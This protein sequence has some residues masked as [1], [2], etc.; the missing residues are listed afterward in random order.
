M[1]SVIDVEIDAG[2]GSIAD[3]AVLERRLRDAVN[4][5]PS[6]AELWRALAAYQVGG[7]RAI[8]L[9]WA[10]AAEAR[11]MEDT[12]LPHPTRS[13][14]PARPRVVAGVALFVALSGA[15]GSLELAFANEVVLPGI[16]ANGLDLGG[17]SR[18][19]ALTLLRAAAEQRAARPLLLRAGDAQ[20]AVPLGYLLHDRS[21]E[22]ADQAGQYGHE[23]A[24]P[25]RLLARAAALGGREVPVDDL[26][27]DAARVRALA[28]ELART[29]TRPVVDATLT[30]SSEGWRIAAP[31]SGRWV[32]VAE[33]ERAIMAALG[34]EARDSTQTG[35]LV[36]QL[37]I[38]SAHPRVLAVDLE[39]L[40]QRLDKLH[41]LPLVVVADDRTWQLDRTEFLVAPRHVSDTLAVDRGAL[42]REIERWATEIDQLPAASRLLW[43]DDRVR[44]IVPGQ[45]GR[46]LDR[47][48]ATEALAA[49]IAGETPRV[50]LPV[51]GAPPPQGE[52][53]ALG[54]VAELARGESAFSTYT[55]PERDANVEAGGKDIDGVVIPPG[56]VFSFNQSVGSIT[57]EKGYR[58]GDMIEAGQ[59]RPALGGG[60]CQV[61]T[62]VF[63]AAFWS[64]LEILEWHP[65]SWRLP[66]Y[67]IGAPPGMDSTIMFGVADLRFRNNTAAHI[68]LKVTTDLAL[69]RQ[70]VV[71]YGTP[72]DRRVEMDAAGEGSQFS[73]QRRVMMGETM[74]DEDTF[75]SM[76]TQ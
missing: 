39:P 12:H 72:T 56:G 42:E 1:V 55:S 10:E 65:H 28:Q 50:E 53:E 43:S 32:E 37:P 33:A 11:R 62:T 63:R 18:H 6:D 34:A 13:P 8:C 57:W 27:I 49:A 29:L 17:L 25:A 75:A 30:W 38:R 35:P 74:V 60:I 36:V 24:L 51:V 20:W 58:W 54:L 23:Q 76:Y 64:G 69:K 67:E 15:G 71:I 19:E 45:P 66:W 44:E 31:Q 14:R 48:A 40:R 3:P 73:V 5:N 41:D 7:R 46:T 68:V 21:A 2:A 9:R 47:S 22:A 16:A 70:T 59:L 61:S 4:Q 52:A 26:E